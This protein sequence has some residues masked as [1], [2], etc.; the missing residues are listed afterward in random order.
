MF[1]QDI[2]TT[3]NEA[4]IQQECDALEYESYTMNVACIIMQ[5]IIDCEDK[6]IEPNIM[7]VKI[8]QYPFCTGER[9]QRIGDCFG[10]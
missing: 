9:T 8:P 6:G 4:C 5:H 2:L 7:E 3:L 10:V 1:D